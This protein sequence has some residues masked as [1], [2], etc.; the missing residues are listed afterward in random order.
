MNF[1]RKLFDRIL[2][3]DQAVIYP[4]LEDSGEYIL[5]NEASLITDIGTSLALKL[6][7]IW[8]RSSNPEPGLDQD[9]FT[10]ILG[11]QYSFSN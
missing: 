10:W 7:N 9:D 1:L 4:S 5:R 8:E 2:F 3:T 6:S 11:L